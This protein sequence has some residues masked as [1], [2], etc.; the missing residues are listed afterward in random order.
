MTR[1]HTITFDTPAGSLA[2]AHSERPAKE[3]GRPRTPQGFWGKTN[4]SLAM[5]SSA[6]HH[7]AAGTAGRFSEKSLPSQRRANLEVKQPMR[8]T[9]ASASGKLQIQKADLIHGSAP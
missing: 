1:I 6:G 2:W 5:T 7:G 9:S 4:T 3:H 8:A